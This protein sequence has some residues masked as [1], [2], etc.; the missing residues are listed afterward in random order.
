MLIDVIRELIHLI[1]AFLL[2]PLLYVLRCFF[3]SGIVEGH[4]YTVLGVQEVPS[5]FC[6]TAKLVKMRNPWGNYEWKGPYSDGSRYWTDEAKLLTK[7]DEQEDGVF[8][9]T[10][11]DFMAYYEEVSVTYIQPGVY[12]TDAK[13]FWRSECHSLIDSDEQH[14]SLDVPWSVQCYKFTILGGVSVASVPLNVD[15]RG[16]VS[17]TL[18][19]PN[20]GDKQ[21]QRSPAPAWALL[22]YDE[23]RNVAGRNHSSPLR[24]MMIAGFL[25]NPQYAKEA[26]L[27]TNLMLLSPGQYT[28]E[29]AF[30]EELEKEE[31]IV[32]LVH[33]TCAA[34]LVSDSSQAFDY[35][36]MRDST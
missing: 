1:L 6:G 10:L 15:G 27:S 12:I 24:S 9:M 3:Y 13:S 20:D 8:W 25:N 17:V 4:A 14:D 19:D 18:V 5:K 30:P 31:D 23:S 11:S 33:S 21:G 26:Y 16:Q 28:V 2:G 36:L 29:I 7:L 35:Q 32:L 34:T 22:V